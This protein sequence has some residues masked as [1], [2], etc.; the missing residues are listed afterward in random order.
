MKKEASSK[1]ALNMIRY[2]GGGL[3][4]LCIASLA[5]LAILERNG[6]TRNILYI[7]CFLA[8]AAVFGA[9]GVVTKN[10][11]PVLRDLIDQRYEKMNTDPIYVVTAPSTPEAMRRKL[12]DIGFAEDGDLMSSTVRKTTYAAFIRRT[13][14]FALEVEPLCAR[15]NRF[16]KAGGDRL[17][18]KRILYAIFYVNRIDETDDE[19]IKTWTAH[20]RAIE[21]VLPITTNTIVPILFDETVQ[22]FRFIDGGASRHRCYDIALRFFKQH[23]LAER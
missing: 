20:E 1:H 16:V 22:D 18:R 14:E 19:I 6:A 12:R 13:T 17:G 10:L 8:I 2:L 3:F 23:I 7:L 5:A 4:L 21:S 9:I 15:F 11:E